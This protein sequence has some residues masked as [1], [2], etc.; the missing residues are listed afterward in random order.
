MIAPRMLSKQQLSKV[1]RSFDALGQGTAALNRK[2]IEIAQRNV[3]SGFDLAQSLSNRQDP[4]RDYGV[5]GDLL[6]QAIQ[7][8]WRLKPRKF[9]R[10]PSRW[11]LT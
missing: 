8:L 9:A 7:C 5:A 10:C 6:A 3:S 1:A 11:Q 2:I 4:R